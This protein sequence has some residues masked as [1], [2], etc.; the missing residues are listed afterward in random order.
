MALSPWWGLLAIPVLV[1]IGLGWVIGQGGLL[2]APL[3][4]YVSQRLHRSVRIDQ[5]QLQFSWTAPQADFTNLRIAEPDWAGPGD[6]LVA[7]H[8]RARIAWSAL[9]GGAFN[10]PLLE[11]DQ[12]LLRLKRA[13]DGRANW[14]FGPATPSPAPFHLPPIRRMV[15]TDG[16]LEMEDLDRQL[17]FSG[18]VA[19]KPQGQA[20]AGALRITAAGSLS[21]RPF[22]M[23]M[24]GAPV[25]DVAADRPYAVVLHARDGATRLDARVALATPFDLGRYSGTV[26][27][28]GDD[29]SALYGLT[30]AVLPNTPPYD[31]TAQIKRDNARYELTGAFGRVG[32][33]DIEGD[34]VVDKI[35][36]RRK[37]QAQLSSRHL[38]FAD[39]TS[40]VGAAPHA[41][42][43]AAA[44]G[45]KPARTPGPVSGRLGL[46]P[47][48]PLYVARLRKFDARLRY[49]AAAVESALALRQLDLGLSLQGGVLT[50]NPMV[51]QFEHGRLAG[52]LQIDVKGPLPRSNLDLQLT[53][54]RLE[55]LVHATGSRIALTAPL[56]G[57]AHV[58]GQGLSVHATAATLDGRAALILSHGSVD[59]TLTS[60]AG[61]AGVDLAKLIANPPG[62]T[63]LRCGLIGFQVQDGRFRLDP[64]VI[65]TGV[66]TL[67][68]TGE[69][70][71]GAE[72]VEVRVIGHS[73]KPNLIRVLAPIT[74]IGPLGR[75]KLGVDRSKIA[76]Q[77]VTGALSSVLSLGG[78]LPIFSGA[79]AT[80]VN[81]AA[82]LAGKVGAGHS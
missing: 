4:A 69:V 80:D 13:P 62:R 8:G 54:A 11:V 14:R 32:G 50:V 26:H 59:R 71:L 49:R 76:A 64:A 30:G 79:A 82:L 35:G 42:S 16:R 68:G 31:V 34:I 38:L 44:E 15:I 47:T 55:D 63:D 56:S 2:R 9:L 22:A 18:T 66:A 58:H 48:A 28:R 52:Q 5:L 36:G 70:D 73:K 19:T 12:P 37:V 1:V 51:Y 33:S 24:T 78:T 65:D 20:D 23:D 7:A 41:A 27:S 61:G 72:R 29:L 81:C 53:G 25:T 74:L 6:M 3:E 43:N 10:M 75:P 45:V 77:T 21:G 17:V 40:I 67:V 39:L 60:L 57:Y 46:L